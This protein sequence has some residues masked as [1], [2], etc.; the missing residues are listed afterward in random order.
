MKKTRILGAVLIPN[1]IMTRYNPKIGFYQLFI[2][3]KTIA[4]YKQKFDKDNITDLSINHSS[5]ILKNTKL[6]NSFLITTENQKQL[7]VSFSHLPIG[8]WMIEYTITDE[9]D[10]KSIEAFKLT[11]FSIEG[12]FTIEDEN[13]K[14]FKV[15]EHFRIMNKISE[16]LSFNIY[17][18]GGSTEGAGRN[19]HGEA[20]FELKEKNSGKK[21][22]KIFMPTKEKW[23]NCNRKERLEFMFVENGRQLTKRE[24]KILVEWLEINNS[25]NLLRCHSEWN[26][27]NKDNNRTNPI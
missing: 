4:L 11:G 12:E 21:L 22:G 5:E 19:E 20:H 18:Q 14:Q 16:L 17:V 8:T 13:G 9:L 6:S 7:D 2:S 15:T 1:F 23:I 24:K 25:E 10:V 27:I 26:E 3:P